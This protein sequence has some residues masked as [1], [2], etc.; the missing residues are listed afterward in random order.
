MV[1]KT[2]IMDILKH[3]YDP[4]YK[5]KSIVEMGL[6][7]ENGISIKDD[8]VEVRYRVTALMCPFS[9]AIGVMI[10][11]ALEKKI[12]KKV[13]L[14]LETDHQGI[15][16]KILEDEKRQAEVLEKLKAYGILEQC[17]KVR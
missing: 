13:K 12:N 15:V 3:V 10:R 8:I 6:V 17:V 4:D 9:A 7:D 14:K 5:D 2:K 1:T 11:Y 16:N